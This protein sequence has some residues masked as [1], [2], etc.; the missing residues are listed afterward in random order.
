MKTIKKKYKSL[1]SAESYHTRLQNRHHYAKLVRTP[2]YGEVGEYVW[3]VGSIEDRLEYL[4]GEL[5]RERISYGELGE[6]QSL[7][8]HIKAGDVELAEPAGISEAEFAAR[9]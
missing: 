9:V 4:R 6:L 5:R 2:R 3:E 8:C 1:K 7:A